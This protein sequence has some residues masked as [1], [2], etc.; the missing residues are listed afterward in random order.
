MHSLASRLSSGLLISLLIAFALLAVLVSVNIRYVTDDYVASRLQHDTETLLAAISFDN[1]GRLLLD[2]ARIDQVYNQPF[3]GH[4]YVIS[5]GTQ[6]FY[7]R[8]LWDQRIE[9]VV[10][11]SGQQNRTEQAGPEQQS[12]LVLSSGYTLQG[13]PLSISLAE[14]LRP[15]R[16]DIDQFIYVFIFIAG[17]ILLVLIVLQVLILRRSLKPLQQV[18][19]QLVQLE[20][21]KIERLDSDVPAEI[22]P[23]I[24]EVNQL[25]TTMGQRLQRS[26]DSLGDLAHAIK[27]PLTVMRQTIRRTESGEADRRVLMEQVDEIVRLSDRILKRARLAGHSHSEQRFAFDTDLAALI[28]TL[29]LMYPDSNIQIEQ[30]I[31]AEVNC[32]VEREDMMELL[33]NLLDN[34]CK[35]AQHKVRITV[36]SGQQLYISIEDDGPGIAPQQ[37]DEL[38]H[39]GK[40]LDESV[41]GHGFGLAI[42]SDTVDEYQGQMHFDQSPELGGLKVEIVLPLKQK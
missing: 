29:G 6:T 12:L 26:R 28:E 21:G 42:A 13:Y 39:R 11:D 40:R 23:V 20:Q 15:I 38:L 14:D 19:Q 30:R 25:L 8:S 24:N 1:D 7:S 4:Y 27:K 41:E 34:A 5:S 10:L 2:G 31:A 36:N 37:I 33:G 18:K 16:Q 32:P 3:S 35:W 9:H 22:E 17:G